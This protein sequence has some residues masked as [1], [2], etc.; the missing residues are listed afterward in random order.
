MQ[1]MQKEKPLNLVEGKTCEPRN[2][3]SYIRRI[4]TY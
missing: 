3:N 2:D 4:V 1:K